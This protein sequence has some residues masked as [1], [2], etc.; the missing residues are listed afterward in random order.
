[1]Q[2]QALQR[3]VF[4]FFYNLPWRAQLERPSKIGQAGMAAGG[5]SG[6][7]SKLL[8]QT[9]K[10]MVKGRGGGGGA[11]TANCGRMLTIYM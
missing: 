4:L 8:V 9:G 3:R 7:I 6:G 2:L 1:M 10:P 11:Q 5:G